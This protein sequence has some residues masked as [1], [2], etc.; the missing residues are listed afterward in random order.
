MPDLIF[1]NEAPEDKGPLTDLRPSGALRN[2][3]IGALP[4]LAVPVAVAAGLT[5]TFL[6][7]RLSATLR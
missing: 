4:V 5:W 1:T 6:T 3:G 7:R 2:L